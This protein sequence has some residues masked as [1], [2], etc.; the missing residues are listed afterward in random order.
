MNKV[1]IPF[2]QDSLDI[3]DS[4]FTIKTQDNFDSVGVNKPDFFLMI[5]VKINND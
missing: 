3:S 5:S 4:T 1:F 2:N